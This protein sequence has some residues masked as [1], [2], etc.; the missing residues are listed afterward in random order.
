MMLQRSV[1]EIELVRNAVS[2]YME[3]REKDV[4]GKQISVQFPDSAI[5]L[6]GEYHSLKYIYIYT[7]IL[8]FRQALL[9]N[10]YRGFGVFLHCRGRLVFPSLLLWGS[11]ERG[12]RL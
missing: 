9:S 6:M 1:K 2:L 12:G 5:E 10:G 8:F 7:H 4:N 3:A 11:K